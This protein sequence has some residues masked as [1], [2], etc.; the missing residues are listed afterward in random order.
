MHQDAGRCR[1]VC[2]RKGIVFVVFS[3]G[4]HHHDFARVALRVKGGDTLFDGSAD[5]RALD[6]YGLWTDGI[7]KEFDRGEVQRQRC[8]NIGVPCENHESRA[9]AI[10]SSHDPFDGALG[11]VQSRHAQV[12][13]HHGAADI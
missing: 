2:P 1:F 7:E 5:G 10:E 13:R 4:E 12:F 11:Q 8:L 6:R 3:I 9:V